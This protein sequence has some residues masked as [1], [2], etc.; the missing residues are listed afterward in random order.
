MIYIGVTRQETVTA[1][2]EAMM[3]RQFEQITSILPALTTEN[4]I[5]NKIAI[6][7]RRQDKV[8]E[9]I[10]IYEEIM[11]CYKRSKVVMRFHAVPGMS[12]YINYTGFLETHNE[13]EKAVEIGK[14]GLQHSLEC[15][16]GDLA[17]DILANLSLVY[18]KQGLPVIEESYL[19]H[20]YYL[21]CLYGRE[22]VT[23]KLQEAYQ[24]KFHKL[25]S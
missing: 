10:H 5:W 15:C 3:N 19:R 7:L 21:I 11:K 2:L 20:S 14:E 18:G 8:E 22:N 13:L 16:R 17:G 4:M 9:A 6:N 1:G 12:L 23:D 25:I 24:Q